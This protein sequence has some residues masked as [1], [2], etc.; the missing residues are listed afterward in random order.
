MNRFGATSSILNFLSR[1]PTDY[2]VDVE[3]LIN[4]I[5][6][7]T[8]LVDR[9]RNTILMV[10]NPLAK[11]WGAT[12][13]DLVGAPLSSLTPELEPGRLDAASAGMEVS[14][15]RRQRVA[16]QARIGMCVPIFDTCHLVTF[17]LIEEEKE[18]SHEELALHYKAL[19][20]LSRL[21]SN[22]DLPDALDKAIELT[23]LITSSRVVCLYQAVPDFPILRCIAKKDDDRVFPD[24]VSYAD[25]IRLSTTT[26]WQAGR[27][28]TAE[29]QRAGRVCGLSYVASTPLGQNQAMIGLLVVGDAGMQPSDHL[30]QSLSFIGEL[31]TSMLQ[32]CVRVD[33]LEQQN[34]SLRHQSAISET[35]INNSVQ[36]I[37][38]L[39]PD[40][41]IAALNNSA[42]GMLGYMQWEVKSQPVENILIGSDALLPALEAA[43]QGKPTNDFPHLS[44]HRR[45]GE[46]FPAEVQ[47]LP[48][49]DNNA[50]LA[51]II[52]INDI[53]NDMEIRVHAKQL[54]HSAYLGQFTAMFAHEVRNPINNISAGLQLME[55]RLQPGDP[56]LESIGKML[57]DCTR[58]DHLM[59][60]VLSFSRPM[61]NT[62]VPVDMNLLIKRIV[63]RWMPRFTRL[64]VKLNYQ[65]NPGLP[66]VLG[67]LR[68]LEQVFINLISNAVEAMS[69]QG[70]VL[71]IR[72]APNQELS[73]RPQLEVM[74][75][76]TGPGIPDELRE[77]IFEPFVTG[78]SKGT[79][80]GLAI[81]KRIISAHQGS[82]WVN[83][84]PGGTMF[85]ILL[86]IISE[87]T[88][89][90]NV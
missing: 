88:K 80:L 3:V 71:S 87:P 74:I 79:G 37:I 85:H 52:L 11:I 82:I 40:L 50:I 2:L 36:G 15:N 46:I 28:H 26:I 77:R 78:K 73:N 72:I 51:I 27:K 9:Q 32:N 31:I 55:T 65:M 39:Q 4:E 64:K 76:D 10:N 34:A 20:E 53:S 70:G 17:N 57:G 22:V 90:E 84:F 59:E 63:D 16:T 6:T 45:D 54:E 35:V 68:A 5:G 44:L 25:L 69:N 30:P 18:L 21:T 7:P 41:K 13:Q 8:V 24:E 60:S 12:G 43:I 56:Q 75:S 61:E 49:I 19:Y 83:S 47:V 48:V 81:T 29:V 67:D 23:G 58:L 89:M 33:N 62:F 1:K 42:E 14:I 66:K 38:I 86:P